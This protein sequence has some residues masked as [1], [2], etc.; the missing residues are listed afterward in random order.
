MANLDRYRMSVRYHGMYGLSTMGFKDRKTP[1]AELFPTADEVMLSMTGLF[2]RLDES[3]AMVY[4]L[5]DQRFEVI[6]EDGDFE[7]ALPNPNGE[8]VPLIVDVLARDLEEARL[9]MD[10]IETTC[11]LIRAKLR[12]TLGVT[13]T[14]EDDYLD[15][16]KESTRLLAT[17]LSR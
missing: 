9:M 5:A 4:E 14:S 7:L 15:R 12:D 3:A 2:W 11:G 6:V 17:E 10:D 13:E 1:L 16:L 8:F